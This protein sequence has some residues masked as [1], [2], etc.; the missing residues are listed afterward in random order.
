MAKTIA[1]IGGYGGMGKFFASTFFFK[2]EKRARK[3]KERKIP[4]EFWLPK[5]QSNFE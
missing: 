1:I 3:R 5:L 2:K 4:K